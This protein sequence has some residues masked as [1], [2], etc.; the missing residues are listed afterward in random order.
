M[1]ERPGQPAATARR[2]LVEGRVQG[3]GFRY[4]TRAQAER[5]GVVGWA[6]N[7]ADGRVEVHAQGEP[8]GV[9][10]LVAWLAM[11]PPAARVTRL[12]EEPAAVDPALA[13]FAIRG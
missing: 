11:G 6:C 12:E 1:R 9:A 13:G 4:S 3:V 7:L 2:V 10:A 5:L 8:A